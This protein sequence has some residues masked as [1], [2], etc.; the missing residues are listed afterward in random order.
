MDGTATQPT[1][2]GHFS[3]VPQQCLE[4]IAVGREVVDLDE[5]IPGEFEGLEV[6]VAAA[7]AK[8]KLAGGSEVLDGVCTDVVLLLGVLHRANAVRLVQAH[9]IAA[10]V[11]EKHFILRQL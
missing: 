8:A 10:A 2:L 4:R 7:G 5:N 11:A 1:H 9:Q 3:K 6:F